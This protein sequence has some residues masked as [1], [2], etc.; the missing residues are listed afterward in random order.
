[1][2]LGVIFDDGLGQPPNIEKALSFYKNAANGD[3]PMALIRLARIYRNGKS[4]IPP[5]ISEAIFWY[6]KMLEHKQHYEKKEIQ[7]AER[8]LQDNG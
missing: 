2:H 1:L 3:E 8:F 5:D 7:E 4:S 6:K